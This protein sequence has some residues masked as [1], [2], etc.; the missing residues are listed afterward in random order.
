[1]QF[2]Y[3][4]VEIIYCSTI[5]INDSIEIMTI[6]SMASSPFPNLLLMLSIANGS[7]VGYLVS[8]RFKANAAMLKDEGQIFSCCG[9]L[10]AHVCPDDERIKIINIRQQH[11]SK[12]LCG[13]MTSFLEIPVCGTCVVT[14][15]SL[16]KL[17]ILVATSSC[18]IFVY[19]IFEGNCVSRQKFECMKI[20]VI[21]KTKSLF[22]NIRLTCTH[23]TKYAQLNHDSSF[24]AVLLDDGRFCLLTLQGKQ[25]SRMPE[26]VKIICIA[27]VEDMFLISKSECSIEFY[28]I[29]RSEEGQ[30]S[31]ALIQDMTL[32]HSSTVLQI[33]T[34]SWNPSRLLFVDASA[35]CFLYN[36]VTQELIV[37]P[38][39]PDGYKYM[40]WDENKIHIFDGKNLSIKTYI[41]LPS[42]MRHESRILEAGYLEVLDDNGSISQRPTDNIKHKSTKTEVPLKVDG[43]DVYSF[44]IKK[45]SIH[46]S[47]LNAFDLV[48]EEMLLCEHLSCYQFK[49]AW[50]I[51]LILDKRKFYLAV[52]NTALQVMEID[53]ALIVYRK[54]GDAGMVLALQ[55]LKAS[56]VENS[57]LLSA[58]LALV[59]M[60]YALAQDNFLY[61]AKINET[62]DMYTS[63]MQWDKAFTI[64]Q[65]YGYKKNI[66]ICYNYAHLL[67]KNLEY[68]QALSVYQEC[69]SNVTNE[70][71]LTN[72]CK[73]GQTRVLL[74]LGEIALGMQYLNELDDPQLYAS[75][76]EIL[77]QLN[78]PLEAAESYLKAGLLPKSASKFLDAGKAV[79]VLDFL[80]SLTCKAI[81]RQVG[82]EL[83]KQGILC[84]SAIVYSKAGDYENAIRLYILDG[85]I[86]LA[87]NL[88]IKSND[89]ISA[90]KVAK[91]SLEHNRIDIAIHCYI[92]AG[93][94]DSALNT[95]IEFDEISNFL[96]LSEDRIGTTH[97]DV[98]GYYLESKERYFDAFKYFTVALNVDKA[99]QVMEENFNEDDVDQATT[100]VA[101]AA[102][103]NL[104]KRY[105]QYLQKFTSTKSTNLSHIVQFYIETGKFIEAQKVA[106]TLP[107]IE[108][109]N[110]LNISC[111]ILRA[112]VKHNEKVL[113]NFLEVYNV[114]LTFHLIKHYASKRDDHVHTAW[115]LLRLVPSKLHCFPDNQFQI[116]VSAMIEC[117]RSGLKRSALK[118]AQFLLF[119]EKFEK[120][121]KASKLE[122]KVW[123]IESLYSNKDLDAEDEIPQLEGN[124]PVCSVSGKS[125]KS[126]PLCICP[127]SGMLAIYDEYLSYLNRENKI[128]PNNSSIGFGFDPIFN[129]RLER[130]QI[131]KVNV[132]SAKISNFL[133]CRD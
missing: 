24:Y 84:K 9:D 90:K 95:A 60:D 36:M 26:G 21:I 38:N 83:E 72:K 18:E 97:A 121:L 5:N 82:R 126:Q 113:E 71:Q 70:N 51:S 88:A 132:N 75:C 111:R 47:T 17:H 22:T 123:Q 133:F 65:K 104:S 64:A 61:C 89:L 99:I 80:D 122:K 48:D 30:L 68:K 19:D 66:Q 3:D 115:L 108:Y 34:S 77:E 125:V 69:L 53:W 92:L 101:K 63:L 52:A 13:E 56:P 35:A 12:K 127:N 15:L 55:E 40:F 10:I 116:V 1:V 118:C 86:D 23:F 16:S 73:M 14:N 79:K 130:R 7:V 110:I 124:L 109:T 4:S 129:K 91:Y 41:Y 33:H 96:K 49:D 39:F 46:R 54:L 45:A 31:L 42:N 106:L 27:L 78:Q 62:I 107:R 74:Q 32:H 43:T 117:Q 131:R 85:K 11:M 98:L 28:V 120:P 103:E 25:I 67:E 44:A 6:K 87:L 58:H 81:L 50:N 94:M 57:R 105:L 20:K 76:G 100:V 8:N 37:M 2:S 59:N 112:L 102:D 119:D 93:D 114:M 128:G 29:E